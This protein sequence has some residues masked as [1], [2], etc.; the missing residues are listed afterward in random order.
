MTR[1]LLIHAGRIPH[2]RVPI[3]SYLSKYL[4][5]YGFELF[6]VSDD[7]QMDTQDKIEF[8]YKKTK[9]SVFK[10]AQIIHRQKIDIIIDY[11]ELKH[12]YLFPTY[13]VAKGIMGRK[14]IYWGQGRD[15]LDADARLKNFAYAIEQAMCDAIILYGECLKE[16][17]PD[18]FHRKLFYANNTLYLNYKGLPIGVTREMVL[19]EYG[20]KTKKN[21]ICMGRMQ[22]RKRVDRLYEA[23]VQ[24]DTPDVGLILVG[25]DPEGVLTDINGINVYKT[26]SIYGDKRFDL[27]TAADVYCLPG[28]VGLSIVD[29]FYCGLPFITEDGDVSA[30]IMYLKDS[31]NGFIVPRDDT[32]ALSEKL[33]LLLYDDEIRQNFSKSA[34]EEI[35]QNANIEKM[36]SG[37]RDALIYASGQVCKV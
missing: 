6:V 2:Y 33:E 8:Q 24:M 26:G 19:E 18:R 34:K 16:Y 9:L 14:I 32:L 37:F 28:A 31:V 23:F 11:M 1:I 36:C 22:K 29:A 4:A 21:I 35:S 20:I 30:E 13:I 27:L 3:Y 12:W 17:V 5:E 7:I 15:L 10:I 25:P